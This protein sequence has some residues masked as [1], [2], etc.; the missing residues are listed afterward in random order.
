MELYVTAVLDNPWAPPG[1]LVMDCQ[2]FAH[3]DSVARSKVSCQL[4]QQNQA[5]QTDEKINS[6][7]WSLPLPPEQIWSQVEALDH[8]EKNLLDTVDETASLTS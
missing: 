8:Q 7:F 2:D 3:Q 5:R 6:R 4:C 1:Q